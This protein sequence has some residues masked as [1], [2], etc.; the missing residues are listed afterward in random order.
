[1][2]AQGGPEPACQV[3]RRPIGDEPSKRTLIGRVHET[4]PTDRYAEAIVEW[5]TARRS[6]HGAAGERRAARRRGNT[7][8]AR[9]ALRAAERRLEALAD[10]LTRRG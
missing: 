10:E 9:D 4:C 8:R 1:M 2:T 7:D 5:A 3:C 6:L